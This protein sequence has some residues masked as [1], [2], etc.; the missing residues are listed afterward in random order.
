LLSVNLQLLSKR[1]RKEGRRIF[2]QNVHTQQKEGKRID[3]TVCLYCGSP[4]RRDKKIFP[5]KEEE[6]EKHVSSH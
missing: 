4:S 3:C 6:E 5:E 1:T 2:I